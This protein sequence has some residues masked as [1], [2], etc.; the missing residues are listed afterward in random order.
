MDKVTIKDKTFRRY[1]SAD[2]IA[3]V[4]KDVASRLN[5]DYKDKGGEPP[6]LLC[7]LNGAMFF[8]VGLMLELDFPVQV[9]SIK[10][11]SY[12]GT[13]SSGHI[14][15]TSP[16][17]SDVKGRE[18]IICED[19]VDT[20][21]TMEFLLDH[22]KSKGAA[23]VRICSFMFKP[24]SFGKPFSIDYIG[25][26]IPNDFIVGFG[27]DYDNMGRNLKGIYSLDK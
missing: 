21:N 1:M 13:S 18:V 9:E 7:V 27:F 26:S 14:E 25:K 23:K 3:S 8:A 16:L 4:I 2:E 24:G 20:G 22:L 6:I 11:R 5:K 12:E 15:L 17:T 19:I 10:L